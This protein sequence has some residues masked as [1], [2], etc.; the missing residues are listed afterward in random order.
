MLSDIYHSVY[1]TFRLNGHS[2]KQTEGT[3]VTKRPQQ[4]ANPPTDKW[5][6]LPQPRTAEQRLKDASEQPEIHMLC[7][8]IWQSGELHILFADTGVGKSIMAVAIADAL[9]KGESFLDL[10]NECAVMNVLLYDFELSDKQVEKRYSDSFTGDVYCFS[11]NFFF[12]TVDFIQL[13]ELNPDGNI[14]DLLFEKIRHDVRTLGIHVL[15]IDNITY[16][17]QY[18]T[19][20]TEAALTL[21]RRLVKLK[22]EFLLSIL[23]LAHTPKINR[24]EPISINHLA[25]SKQL[26]NFADSVSAIGRSVQDNNIRYWKQI[27]PSRSAELVYDYN[28]VITCELVKKDDKFLTYEL[29]EFNCE[30]EHLRQSEEN[31]RMAKYQE[32]KELYDAGKTYA[33]I[34]EE[35]LGDTKLKGTIYKWIKK[36]DS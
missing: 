30:R 36:V 26:P 34:A 21:M 8:P 24:N 10:S 33:Q 35:L 25:G 18:T 29:L 20:K 15:I 28:N 19:Q 22:R 2:H 9:S 13:D 32:A 27:K 31:S 5:T 23:V 14:D 4:P 1:E 3:G 11:P 17:N 6:K 12:D 16:L 7:G